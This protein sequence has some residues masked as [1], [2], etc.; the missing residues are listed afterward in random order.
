MLL[1]MADNSFKQSSF[2][3]VP[4]GLEMLLRMLKSPRPPGLLSIADVTQGNPLHP[5]LPPPPRHSSDPCWRAGVP[6]MSRRATW[7]SM[8]FR[9]RC[10]PTFQPRRNGDRPPLTTGVLHH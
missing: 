5:Y 1:V 7:G 10:N 6:N 9:P 4:K 8:S 3:N 2:P